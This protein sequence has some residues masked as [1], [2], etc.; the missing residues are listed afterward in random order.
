M[1]QFMATGH[2]NYATDYTSYTSAQEISSSEFIAV[3]YYY[4]FPANHA[5]FSQ[6]IN[7]ADKWLSQAYTSLSDTTFKYAA[8]LQVMITWQDVNIC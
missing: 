1:F 8:M 6:V 5:P 2:G 3:S 7:N 4:Y